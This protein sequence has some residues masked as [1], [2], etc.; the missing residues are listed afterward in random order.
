MHERFPR[1]AATIYVRFKP[2]HDY[3]E[4][5]AYRQPGMGHLGNTP[6]ARGGGMKPPPL[7]DEQTHAEQ[8]RRIADHADR[9]AFAALFAHFAPRVK[10]Y[11]RR[12]GAGDAQ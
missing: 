3:A 8:I 11:M 4:R 2:I 9:A 5:R 7:T 10:A 12:L 6:S 1:F